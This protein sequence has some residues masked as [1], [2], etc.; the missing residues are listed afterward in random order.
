MLFFSAMLVLVPGAVLGLIAERNGRE[1]LQRV[2]GR[3]LER[4]AVHVAERMSNAMRVQRETL[5]TFARQEVMR[6]I[7]VLDLDKR[8][9]QALLTLPTSAGVPAR[10]LV[11]DEA[12]AIVASTDPSWWR[13]PPAWASGSMPEAPSTRVVPDGA[14]RT[15]LLFTAPIPDP[16][17]TERSLGTLMGLVDWS[18]VTAVG[19][20]VRDELA[21]QGLA[22]ELAI[23]DGSGELLRAR[24]DDD[25]RSEAGEFASLG[26]LEGAAESDYSVESEAGLIVGRARFD[27]GNETWTLLVIEPLVNALAPAVALRDRLFGTIGIALVVALAFA[28]L[29]ARRVLR[30]LEELTAAIRLLTRRGMSG[31]SV[32]IRSDDEVGTLARAFN[33]MIGEL[34][35]TQRHLVE[36]EK[37]SLVG[38]LAAGVAHQ[39]RTSLGVLGSAAQILGRSPD[40]KADPSTLEMIDMIRAEVRRL[41]R[42]VDDLL[43]LDRRRTPDLR[44]TPIS[45][46]IRSAI[47]F[48]SPQAHE[49]GVSIGFATP[50]RDPSVLLDEEAM[51]QVCVNLLSNAI[52][53]LEPGQA[54]E[55]GIEADAGRFASFTVRDNGRG[56]PAGLQDRIFDPFVTGRDGGVGLGLTF[57]KRVVHDHGGTVELVTSRGPGACF[58]VVL[59]VVREQS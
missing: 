35:R 32:P 44:P 41:G 11:V 4:E 42:V 48:V 31:V 45:S 46:P 1:S 58:R 9:A 25:A 34:D 13:S 21:A 28:A 33:T 15:A 6:E 19:D 2:I 52:S 55:V 16:D 38:E 12:G 43:T 29:G 5:E 50:L 18:L 40:L 39:V 7:R 37:F 27:A 30:P 14:S 56:I 17:R 54:I 22:A 26:G 36:A 8:V 53:A 24:L 20:A 51:T 23:L 49:K 3:E 10:Y 59:P 57:V 47:D